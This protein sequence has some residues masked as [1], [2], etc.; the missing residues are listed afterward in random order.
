MVELSRA[1]TGVW[2]D[3]GRSP[4]DGPLSDLHKKLRNK[5]RPNQAEDASSHSPPDSKTKSLSVPQKRTAHIPSS[6]G[7]DR[8]CSRKVAYKLELPQELSRVHHTF[9]VSNLKKCYADEPFAPPRVSSGHSRCTISSSLWKNPLISMKGDQVI[10]RS[11]LP[12][13]KVYWNCVERS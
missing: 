9:H 4:T 10:E 11:G 3:V 7:W 13:V 6:E 2:A 5:D 1:I 12:L 8:L